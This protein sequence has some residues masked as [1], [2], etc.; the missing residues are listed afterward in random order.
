MNNSNCIKDLNSL[1]LTLQDHLLLKDFTQN[2]FKYL[3]P[4]TYSTSIPMLYKSSLAS[5]QEPTMNSILSLSVQHLLVNTQSS[6]TLN[7]SSILCLSIFYTSS[8]FA[9]RNISVCLLFQTL[10]QHKLCAFLL[11]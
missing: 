4:F 9:Q 10:E 2:T 11:V 5:S 3:K 6:K 7:M 8:N 1:L